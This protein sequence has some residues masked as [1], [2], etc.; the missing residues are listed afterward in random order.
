M[1]P[2]PLKQQESAGIT[3]VFSVQHLLGEGVLTG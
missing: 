2:L 3:P 1:H